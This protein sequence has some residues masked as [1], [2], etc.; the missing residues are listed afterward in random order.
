MKPLFFDSE[1]VKL[2]YDGAPSVGVFIVSL[3]ASELFVLCVC[4]LMAWY[5]HN[6]FYAQRLDW[7]HDLAHEEAD[8]INDPIQRSADIQAC[9]TTLRYCSSKFDRTRLAAC[10]ICLNEFGKLDREGSG[11]DSFVLV[12]NF[13][14]FLVAFVVFCENLSFSH[15]VFLAF[16]EPGQTISA[17]PC[18]HAFCTACITE[19]LQKQNAC[20]CCRSRV[21]PISTELHPMPTPRTTSTTRTPSFAF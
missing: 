11:C 19:W 10:P 2:A 14:S 7:I 12:L 6:H 9:L 1:D 18:R 8:R 13:P 17:G 21:L 20:P 5:S 4:K 15:S 16:T 3:A